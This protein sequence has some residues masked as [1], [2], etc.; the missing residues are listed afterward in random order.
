MRYNS[1]SVSELAEQI[2][3]NVYCFGAGRA[4]E[5]FVKE[6]SR[7][8]LEKEIKA[9]VDNKAYKIDCPKKVVNGVLI[10]VISPEEMV[11]EIS[12]DECIIITTAAYEEVIEQLEKNEKLSKVIYY[13]YLFLRMEQYDNDRLQVNLPSHLS[14]YQERQ[15][16]K[17]IHYCWFGRKGIPIQYKK[18]MES[19]KKY[20]PDYEVIEWNEDNYDV[21]KNRYISQAYELEKWAFVSD[22]ARID[23]INEYG[24][25]YLDT[26]VELVKNID[27]LLQND[28]FCGFENFRY[29]AYGLGFGS[30]KDNAVLSEMLEYYDRMEFLSEDGTLNQITCPVIQTEIMK[31]HGLICN[32]EFQVVQGMTVYPSRTLCGM[33]PHSFRMQRNLDDTYA[34]HHYS[35]SWLEDKQEKNK[36]IF[37]MKKWSENQGYY[38]PDDM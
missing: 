4:F 30:K 1:I 10:P 23:I 8:K 24:G 35:G 7:F 9:I 32:G 34:I 18:W 13:I 37:Y 6:F 12:N 11:A 3:R 36:V 38:Y 31:R 5:A 15:I 22:Y 16:P 19:W 21:H 26:D 20:C 27:V 33:S 17:V 28:A 25:V 2:N 29:V 14:V